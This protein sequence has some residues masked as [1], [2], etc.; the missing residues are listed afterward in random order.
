LFLRL[1]VETSSIWHTTRMF[2]YLVRISVH[3]GPRPFVKLCCESK[4]TGHCFSLVYNN[5]NVLIT[6]SCQNTIFLFME[7]LFVIWFRY[8]TNISLCD[9]NVRRQ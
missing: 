1:E 2:R 8:P 7:Q 6:C 4:P 9:T 3:R 5:V